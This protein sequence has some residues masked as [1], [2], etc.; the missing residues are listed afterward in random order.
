MDDTTFIEIQRLCRLVHERSLRELTLS[1]LDFSVTMTALPT[2]QV[3]MM[4]APAAPPLAG[5]AVIAEPAGYVVTSPLIGIFYRSSSPDAAPFVEVGDMVETGQTI[6]I[7]EA[8]K[9][10]NEIT[11]EQA[12]KVVAI[13]VVNNALVQ[14]D[15]PLVIIDPTA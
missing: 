10:F 2:D 5:P 14:V 8:M 4:N 6:G 3:V 9:V 12:G 15:Q 13:P 7:V 1:R 11:T